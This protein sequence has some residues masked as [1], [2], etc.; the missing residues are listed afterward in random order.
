MVLGVKEYILLALV[1]IHIQYRHSHMSQ[2]FL[3][4][5]ALMVKISK[6]ENYYSYSRQDVNFYHRSSSY[7]RPYHCVSVKQFAIRY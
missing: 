4:N 2:F 7:K 6:V 1:D 3:T 5:L